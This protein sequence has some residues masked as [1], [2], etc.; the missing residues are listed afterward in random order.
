MERYREFFEHIDQ[1][2]KVVFLGLSCGEQDYIYVKEIVRRAENIDF[3]W[4]DEGTRERFQ[5]ICNSEHS[6]VQINFIKW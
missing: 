6:K 4:Y 1:S 5:S 3:F 2:D